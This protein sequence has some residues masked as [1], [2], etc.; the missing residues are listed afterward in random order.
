MWEHAMNSSP[1][2]PSIVPDTAL[3]AGHLVV[4]RSA[5][6][7]ARRELLRK[8]KAHTRAYD[9][10]RHQR[11]SLPWVL[12]DKT[13]TFASPHGPVTLSDLF[14]GRSQLIVQHFMLGPGWKEGCAG[15]SFMADHIDAAR[16][17][18]EPHGI[19]V[20]AVSRATLPEIEA[21]RQRM[22]WHFPW[23]S[24]H[25]SDFNYDF[26]VSFTPEQMESGSTLYNY[27]ES[28]TEEEESPGVSVF[29]KH[30]DGKV[31]HTYSTYSRGLE[32]L[33]G[34]YHFLDLTPLGRREDGPHH[35][36]MD[37]V[38]LHDRY[39]ATPGTTCSACTCH[40]S[41]SGKGGTES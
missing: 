27:E 30:K 20:A 38:R 16:L 22:G 31:Y 37:W 3:P 15:C 10:L 9:V 24:S 29:Y 32:A 12:L 26:H 17:H 19:T 40:D 25:D 5:W 1:T 4:S 2:L 21:F 18:L 34:A 41:G 28:S 23:V 6:L 7:E 8:E 11:Q 13:Y 33:V 35:N 14:Q 36:L 39:E